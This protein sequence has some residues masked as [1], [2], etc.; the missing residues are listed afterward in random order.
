ME[1]NAAG[2]KKRVVSNTFPPTPSATQATAFRTAAWSQCWF[3]HRCVRV[4]VC[5]CMRACE[6][7]L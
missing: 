4:C 2:T 7:E 5:A 3:D 1:A 6:F